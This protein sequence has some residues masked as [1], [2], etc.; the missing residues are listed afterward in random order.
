MKMNLMKIR[1]V[2]LIIGVVC[3]SLI[4]FKTTT[5]IPPPAESTAPFYESALDKSVNHHLKLSYRKIQIQNLKTNQR[6]L[7]IQH[8]KTKN[9]NH[10]IHIQQNLTEQSGLSESEK[11]AL[12]HQ[13]KDYPYHLE[14]E[15]KAQLEE[16]KAQQKAKKA[17]IEAYKQE[18]KKA[19][20]EV[21]MKDTVVLGVKPG[22]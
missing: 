16:Q 18:A 1:L 19:G 9:I 3:L 7:E 14:M 2:F 20:F 11:Q 4:D 8:L 21:I 5:P 10:R 13:L 17:F 6:A 15:E 22:P 12:I